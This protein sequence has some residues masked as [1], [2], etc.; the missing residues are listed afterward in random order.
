[1]AKHF[2]CA[3]CKKHFPAKGV[4]VNHIIPVVP[5]TGFDSW[6]G[7]IARMFCPKEQLEVLCKPCHKLVSAKEREDRKRHK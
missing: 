7:V 3:H 6:D 1:M 4:E 5:V 2:K